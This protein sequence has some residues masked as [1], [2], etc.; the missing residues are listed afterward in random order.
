MLAFNFPSLTE[1]HLVKLGLF[2]NSA[3][4][5]REHLRGKGIATKTNGGGW[6]R[7]SVK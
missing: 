2:I 5:F 7:G 6:G 3:L 1:L 4:L